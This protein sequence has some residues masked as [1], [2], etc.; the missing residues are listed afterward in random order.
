MWSNRRSGDQLSHDRLVENDIGY[1]NKA[2]VIKH[3]LCA[4]MVQDIDVGGDETNIKC[5][6]IGEV[7][8]SFPMTGKI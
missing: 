3:M 6:V 5:G 7:G 2:K 8:T 4:E 1:L